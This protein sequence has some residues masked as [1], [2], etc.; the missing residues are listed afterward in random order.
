MNCREALLPKYRGLMPSFGTLTNE[1]I[2]GGYHSLLPAW[3][4]ESGLRRIAKAGWLPV[5]YLHPRN[6]A[7]D[8]PKASM[9][10]YRRFKCHVGQGSAEDKLRR[11]RQKYPFATC[12]EALRQY[13]LVPVE[14]MPAR[15][16]ISQAESKVEEFQHA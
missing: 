4:I 6:F 10:A 8:C 5:V 14:E 15:T 7:A 13:S 12:F 9:P 16:D 2:D 1:E 3:Q 11:L